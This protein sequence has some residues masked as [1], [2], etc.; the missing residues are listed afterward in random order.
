MREYL[1]VKFRTVSS[2]G[3]TVGFSRFQNDGANVEIGMQIGFQQAME[4]DPSFDTSM[5]TGS[6]ADVV[7]MAPAE[8]GTPLV[9][10]E[11]QHGHV[12]SSEP[13]QE[14]SVAVKEKTWKKLA[15]AFDNPLFG[16]PSTTVNDFL[17][18][19]V[20][21]FGDFVFLFIFQRLSG[22]WSMSSLVKSATQENP[23]FNVAIPEAEVPEPSTL[24]G[25]IID[26]R[27][28]LFYFHCNC[29]L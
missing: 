29:C 17:V 16:V 28:I 8:P 5:S 10:R 26:L 9:A 25:S 20:V 7:S 22:R 1:I 27:A 19:V 12:E 21:I 3:I 6:T 18:F 4:R 13:P 23:I 11:Q 24:S 2:D 15:R 14:R